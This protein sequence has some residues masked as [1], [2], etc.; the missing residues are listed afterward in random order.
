MATQASSGPFALNLKDVLKGLI[1]AVLVPIVTIIMNS[2]NQGTLT[3]NWKQIGIAA[4]GGFIGYLIKNFLTP[5]QIVITDPS[6]S[7]VEAV[8]DG[9]AEAKIVSS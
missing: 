8:K 6:K 9:R 7:Q 2:I 3:F 4:V 1:M 5:A